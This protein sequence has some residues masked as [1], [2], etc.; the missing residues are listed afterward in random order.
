MMQ[1]CNSSSWDGGMHL[2]KVSAGRLVNLSRVDAAKLMQG[3]LCEGVS[4]SGTR[5]PLHNTIH[6]RELLGQSVSLPREV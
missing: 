6:C 2:A 3:S 1:S 4:K 5:F